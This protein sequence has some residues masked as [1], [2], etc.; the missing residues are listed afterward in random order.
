MSKSLRSSWVKALS[1]G[2]SI[3]KKIVEEHGGRIEA[4]NAAE[5]GAQVLV[6]LPLNDRARA[7]LGVRETRKG[8]PRR[9]RA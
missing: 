3:L 4:H 8:E 7:D 2:L 5:G 6:T 9:E 1:L